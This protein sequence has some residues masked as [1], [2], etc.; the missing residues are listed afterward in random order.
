MTGLIPPHFRSEGRCHTAR[1]CDTY[2]SG[3]FKISRTFASEVMRQR[4][5]QRLQIVIIRRLKRLRLARTGYF[6]EQKRKLLQERPVTFPALNFV[7]ASNKRERT[8]A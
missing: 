7:R 1:S 6:P 2:F 4:L 3:P 8:A 5:Q